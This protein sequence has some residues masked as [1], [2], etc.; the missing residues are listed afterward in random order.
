MNHLH[1]CFTKKDIQYVCMIL[2]SSIAYSVGFV[3]FVRSANLFPGGFSGVSRL[4]SI[5]FQIPFAVIYFLLNILATGLVLKKIGNK[6]IL[7][8][9][10]WFSL[11]SVLTGFIHVEPLTNDPLLLS[12]FGGLVNGFAIGLA[13]QAN[14]SSGGTDFIAMRLSMILKKPTWNYV[15]GFNAVIL[16]IAGF[17]YGWNQ[18]LY[19]IIF[20]YSSTQIVNLMHQRYKYTKV[21]VITNIPDDV[22]QAIFHVCRHG[23]TVLRCE[24]GYKHEQ[25]GMLVM[26]ISSYQI[27]EVIDIIKYK[28][29]KAF[30]TLSTVNRVVGNYYH[31]PLD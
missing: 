2:V 18:A 23:I 17:R 24:G 10:L 29:E 22:C 9:V 4:L 26:V 28:D 27:R 7:Y 25:H 15:L 13:L 6:F 3:T 12:I 19:S 5:E 30:I 1:I 14:A 31:K 20:Q 8:T 21:E 16:L 11:T